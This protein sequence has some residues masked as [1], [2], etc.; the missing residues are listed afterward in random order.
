[1]IQKYFKVAASSDATWTDQAVKA[2]TTYSYSVVAVT[3]GVRSAMSEALRV[4][5]SSP[6]R[7]RAVR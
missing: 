2:S 7:S 1:M 5:T 6:S 3:S 4:S